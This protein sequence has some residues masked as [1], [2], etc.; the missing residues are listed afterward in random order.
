MFNIFGLA[1]NH[2]GVKRLEKHTNVLS[3]SKLNWMISS[4]CKY[5]TR[6][7]SFHHLDLTIFLSLILSVSQLQFS[8]ANCPFSFVQI[9][10]IYLNVG[11]TQA[12]MYIIP[13][14]YFNMRKLLTFACYDLLFFHQSPEIIGNK[15]FDTHNL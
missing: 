11:I 10:R 14:W 9:F 6:K 13:P 7:S 15:I 5:D 8:L 1:F 3:C 2:S 4:C 12:G